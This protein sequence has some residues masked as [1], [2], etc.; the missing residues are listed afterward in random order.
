MFEHSCPSWSYSLA[1]GAL[2]AG[3]LSFGP[4]KILFGCD[5]NINSTG[6][7]CCWLLTLGTAPRTCLC[8]N[9][10][11]SE[12]VHWGCAPAHQGQTQLFEIQLNNNMINAAWTPFLQHSCFG[13]PFPAVQVLHSPLPTP[14]LCC[15]YSFLPSDLP[16]GR[17]QISASSFQSVKCLFKPLENNTMP[18]ALPPL[19]LQADSTPVSLAALRAPESSVFRFTAPRDR[20]SGGCQQRGSAGSKWQKAVQGTAHISSSFH[21]WQIK[22][23]WN[24]KISH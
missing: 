12:T 9:P 2:L 10:L 20:R 18:V 14:Q 23:H 8:P 13:D 11:C 24:C 1:G 6:Q 21:Q 7:P 16:K 22:P 4:F 5:Q 17:R 15:Q 19:F 3:L